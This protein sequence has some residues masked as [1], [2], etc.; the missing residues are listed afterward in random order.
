MFS[1]F[2]KLFPR[3]EFYAAAIEALEQALE[4]VRVEAPLTVK[5]FLH[6]TQPAKFYGDYTPRANAVFQNIGVV[7]TS[8]GAS[9]DNYH[10]SLRFRIRNHPIY[11]TAVILFEAC[12]KSRPWTLPVQIRPRRMPAYMAELKSNLKLGAHHIDWRFERC[13]TTVRVE[14]HFESLS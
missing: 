11:F 12:L 9:L 1:Q 2:L 8:E 7:V 3:T 13:L 14:S 5:P 10:R 4:N 6:V